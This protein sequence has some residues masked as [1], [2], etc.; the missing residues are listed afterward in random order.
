MSDSGSVV[1]VNISK[2][3]GTIKLPVDQIVID[4]KGIVSDAHAGPWHRQVSVLSAADVEF[5]AKEAGRDIAH[6]EFAENITTDGLDLGEVSILDRFKIGE[7]ELEVSQIGKK[8]H[9]DGC[10]IFREVGSC[11]M[12]KKGL[13]CRVI[14]GGTVKAGDK[15]EYTARPFKVTVLTMSDRAYAGEYSDRSGP[16]AVELINEFF[17]GKRWHLAVETEILPDD[18]GILL[19]KLERATAD[20]VDVIFTL[21]GTGIGPR[22]IT[23]DVVSSIID[24]EITGIMENIRVKFGAE[25]PSALLSRSVA[26]TLWTSQLY[27]LPGSVK[28][29]TEYLG[30][31]FK[32]LEH[33][34]CMLHGLDVH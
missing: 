32:T 5:F 9:G 2:E 4:D 19:E 12:P 15:I 31:I 20:G 30:E 17:K 29:V 13:F 24:K 7:V 3:K 10:A 26:G 6:G 33:A 23:P 25:K 16:K 34:V 11:V 28:A 14:N 1:S 8:C 22:D 21:G 27:A 18:P